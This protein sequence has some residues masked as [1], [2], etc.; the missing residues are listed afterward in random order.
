[1]LEYYYNAQTHERQ[2]LTYI[3]KKV[4]ATSIQLA[5]HNSCPYETNTIS[6]PST[7]EFKV[8]SF[9][10]R[11]FYEKQYENLHVSTHTH[12]HTHNVKSH[13]DYK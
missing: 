8:V 4:D 6:S 9:V 5:S 1:M 10:I 3:W 12:T 13:W 2:I 7:T 11:E